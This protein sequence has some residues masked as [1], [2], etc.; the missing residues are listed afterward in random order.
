MADFGTVMPSPYQTLFDTNG[1]PVAGG[2]VWTY[3]AGTSYPYPTYTDVSLST[4]NP[5]PI[6]A[7]SAGRFTAWLP[8]ATSYKFVFEGAAVPPAHGAVIRSIDNVT[9]V[10]SLSGYVDLPVTAGEALGALT[11]GYL[12]DGSGGKTAGQWYLAD[13][14]NAWSST[15]PVVGFVI[16]PIAVGARGYVRVVGSV[17]GLVVVTGSSY[18]IGTGGA[19]QTTP[20]PANVRR[21]AVAD[22]TSSLTITAGPSLDGLFA[23][24][25]SANLTLSQA[26]PFISLV[27]TA[28]PANAK[29][30][31]LYNASGSLTVDTTDDAVSTQQTVP[32]K[33]SRAGDAS[34]YRDIYEKQRPTPVGHWI[35]FVPT[36]TASTGT[37]TGATAYAIYSVVGRTL[38]L[39]VSL[40]GG[41]L[42]AVTTNLF[43]STP[44][45]P[46]N[47]MPNYVNPVTFFIAGAY[48]GGVA[49]LQ[50]V[51]PNTIQLTRAAGQ[52]FPAGS[53]TVR[54]T[55]IYPI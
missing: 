15:I 39:E 44:I 5:N 10:P 36:L 2:L 3:A 25:A 22:S 46:A 23:N 17:V 32:L 35:T 14:A 52:Q 37:W 54:G 47:H 4:P 26:S 51:Q 20:P 30:F 55:I 11:V 1:D 53:L 38:T 21:V 8:P 31:R 34:V 7:D 28:Q 12:S 9:P 18:Y 50:I 49:T 43:L 40:E 13:A 27:D 48:E 45:V 29:V 16:T 42:S 33:L 41:T 19:L 24:P 6:V